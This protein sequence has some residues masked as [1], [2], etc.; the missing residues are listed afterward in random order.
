[1]YFGWTGH[2]ITSFINQGVF[3]FS[4]DQIMLAAPHSG[5]HGMDISSFRVFPFFDPFRR[6]GIFG[7]AV[8][9]G[10]FSKVGIAG[11][12]SWAPIDP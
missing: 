4:C 8:K 12:D 3:Y 1:M 7:R 9:Q 10:V 11:E 2:L 6:K 5:M